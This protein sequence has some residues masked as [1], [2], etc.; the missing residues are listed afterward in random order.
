MQQQ[1]HLSQR[2]LV[3]IEEGLL[4]ADALSVEPGSPAAAIVGE[5]DP[6][7]LLKDGGV[8]G[9]DTPALQSD[10]ALARTAQLVFPFEGKPL[11]IELIRL[12]TGVRLGL[13]HLEHPQRPG[14]RFS[15]LH[16][17]RRVIPPYGLY[18]TDH[19]I[20]H[21]YGKPIAHGQSGNFIG[22][23]TQYPSSSF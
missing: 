12:S 18:Q 2:D 14:E 5:Q 11:P 23:L 6:V 10:I 3:P 20:D 16:A 8:D 15:F 4:L 22:V 9:G 21:E 13:N 19:D 17:L 1:D 7:A